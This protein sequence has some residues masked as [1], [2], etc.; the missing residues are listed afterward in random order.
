MLRIKHE[1]ITSPTDGQNQRID[2]KEQMNS[3][4]GMQNKVSSKKETSKPQ[5][6]S[7]ASILKTRF[8]AQNE[9]IAVTKLESLNSEKE[10]EV[11]KSVRFHVKENTAKK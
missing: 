4:G 8:L 9:P 11:P 7:S 2:F 6:P 10:D 1:R 5:R 3:T